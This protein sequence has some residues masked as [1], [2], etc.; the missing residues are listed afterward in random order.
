MAKGHTI[1]KAKHMYKE[2]V[3]NILF[4]GFINVR[5]NNLFMSGFML[6]EQAKLIILNLETTLKAFSGQF[7]L[8]TGVFIKQK[9][10]ITRKIKFEN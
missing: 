3:N 6:Q 5:G 4:K 8:Q 9:Q 2:D 10:S 7:L 1:L